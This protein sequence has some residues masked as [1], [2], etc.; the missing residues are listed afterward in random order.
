MTFAIKC[1]AHRY[2][3]RVAVRDLVVDDGLYVDRLQLE[4]Y[5]HVNE[6]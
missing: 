4:V 2:V 5:S 6:P 3:K 1:V